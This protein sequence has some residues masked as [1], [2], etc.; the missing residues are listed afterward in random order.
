MASRFGRR[1][2]QNEPRYR[3]FWQT[4][5][6]IASMLIFAAL[7]PP[8]TKV[9]GGDMTPSARHDP[10]SQRLPTASVNPSKPAQVSNIAVVRRESDHLVAKNFT[11]HTNL[12]MRNAAIRKSD[13][14]DSIQ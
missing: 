1:R 9:N 8:A 11:N 12:H 3:L 14:H 7:R 10:R 6:I 13:S 5:A 4:A 2:R